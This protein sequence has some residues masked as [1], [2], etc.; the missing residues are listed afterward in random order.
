M[1][2][3]RT[4]STEAKRYMAKGFESLRAGL[5]RE[6]TAAPRLFS[7]LAKV[8]AYIAE[9]YKTRALVELIQNADDAAAR[10]FGIIDVADGFAAGNDGRPF[11]FEDVE[12]LCRSGASHKQRGDT[13]GYRGI[14]FKSVVNL[15]RRIYVYSGEYAF[16]FDKEATKAVLAEFDDVP[17]VRIP[18]PV[19]QQTAA[20]HAAEVASLRAMGCNTVFVFQQLNDRLSSEELETFDSGSLLFLRNVSCVAFTHHGITRAIDLRTADHGRGRKRVSIAEGTVVAEWDVLISARDATNMVAFRRAQEGIVAAR[21][22]ESVFHSF[23]PT[24]QFA[25]AFVK[26]NGDYSTDPSRKHVDM[27]GRSRRALDDAVAIL[28]A[29]AI[30]LL[31][32][33]DDIPGFFTPLIV[34]PGPSSDASKPQLLRLLTARLQQAHLGNTSSA[35]TQFSGI[36]LRPQWLS[37][38]DYEEF[39]RGEIPFIRRS[40]LGKYPELLAFL[41]QVGV[42]TLSLEDVLEKVNHRSLSPLGYAQIFTRVVKQYRYDLGPE[43]VRKIR[44]L[45]LLPTSHGVLSAASETSTSALERRFLNF[46]CDN[47]DAPDLKLVFGKIGVK[48][49]EPI[50]EAMATLPEPRVANLSDTGLSDRRCGHDATEKLDQA[51]R[52]Q[53]PLKRWRSAERNAEEYVRA[54][55]GVAH[56]TDMSKANVGYDLEVILDDDDRL[57]VEV[58]AVSSFSEPFRLTNNEYSSAHQHGN[59]YLIALVINSTPFQIM[60]VRNPVESLT[61]HKQCERWSWYCDDY[62]HQLVAPAEITHGGGPE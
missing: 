48:V 12:A 32:E 50:T 38:D 3:A 5:L 13:I 47:N 54:I 40:L 34:P 57:Y 58:K 21:S 35:T 24:G 10:K 15:A 49:D 19:H 30:D 22:E 28:A 39:C 41:E 1:I 23:T 25:G 17:L 36:R 55:R 44:N 60:F 11:S 61:L 46:L 43:R 20:S 27:D 62:Q 4:Y 14:G 42:P 2:A 7:D 56:V 45:K 16:Y 26:I 37:Y 31:D 53:P 18:H 33:T 8:E 9:S 6:A 51:L 59:R 29:T 52:V